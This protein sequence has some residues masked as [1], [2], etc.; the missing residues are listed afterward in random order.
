MTCPNTHRETRDGVTTDY[1]CDKPAGHD[2]PCEQAQP[3]FMFGEWVQASNPK[4][5]R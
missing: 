2:G 5:N 3:R 4:G 1:R